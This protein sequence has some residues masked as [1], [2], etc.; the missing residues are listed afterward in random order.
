[1]DLSKAG[2]LWNPSKSLEASLQFSCVN[3]RAI[4]ID[5]IRHL[6]LQQAPARIDEDGQHTANIPLLYNCTLNA[7]FLHLLPSWTSSSE[8][9][10]LQ[11][12]SSAS[13]T[14]EAP[15]SSIDRGGRV[16][17]LLLQSTMGYRSPELHASAVSSNR[18]ALI[19]RL[20][21]SLPAVSR[22]VCRIPT[23]R[24]QVAGKA[25]RS[26]GFRQCREEGVLQSAER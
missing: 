8:Y 4:S 2:Q 12:A 25:Q 19:T 20:I 16:S 6:H 14:A 23:D 22:R 3:V 13:N 18:L 9:D 1:M 10:G 5:C 24:R 21:R 17:T 26:K 15:S 7:P 11:R